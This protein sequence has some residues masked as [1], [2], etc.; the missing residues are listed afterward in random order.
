MNSECS[1]IKGKMVF[2]FI[3]A[4]VYS[5]LILQSNIFDVGLFHIV[6]THAQAH[7]QT[8]YIYIY[9]YI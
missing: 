6:H 7:K 5:L 2:L 8:L 9:I 1:F 3:S 4:I